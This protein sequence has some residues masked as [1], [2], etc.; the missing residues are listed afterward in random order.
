MPAATWIVAVR[1]TRVLRVSGTDGG[2]A[3]L[4]WCCNVSD[5]LEF[6]GGF[7]SACELRNRRLGAPDDATVYKIQH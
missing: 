4:Y 6:V 2:A 3:A 7:A 5:W 1:V